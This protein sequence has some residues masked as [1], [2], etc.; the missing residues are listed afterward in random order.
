MPRNLLPRPGP[1]PKIVNLMAPIPD[2]PDYILPGL[3]WTKTFYHQPEITRFWTTTNQWIR[4]EM[5]QCNILN[6]LISVL[7]L[8]S[9]TPWSYSVWECDAWFPF[10]STNIPKILGKRNIW[11]KI[12][13]PGLD[14]NLYPRPDNI[15][16]T[17]PDP[18]P[19]S[20]RSS[21]VREISGFPVAPQVFTS[22]WV[23]RSRI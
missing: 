3:D 1:N 16:K 8:A 23:W 6:M 18:R 20:V 21:P 11:Y 2:R 4:P 14:Q 9:Y 13:R 19:V 17:C 15:L 22:D 7:L 5:K 10:N 12:P